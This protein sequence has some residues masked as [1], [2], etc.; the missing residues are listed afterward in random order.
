VEIRHLKL[1]RELAESGTL[2]AAG[3]RLF[4]TQPALSRQL[5][6]VENELGVAVFQ[7]AGRK[8]KLTQAGIRVH[9][10]ACRIVTELEQTMNDV[11]ALVTGGGILRF[12]T[13]CYT[14]YHW[15]PD[16]LTLYR[17]AYPAVEVSI[18][19][20]ATAD[21][22]Q[23]LRDGDLDVGLVNRVVPGA[24]LQY[25]RLFEDEDVVVVSREHRW[26]SRKFVRPAELADE[27]LIVFDSELRESNLFKNVLTPAGVTPKQVIK[28]P[29][30]EAIVD[31]IKAGLGISVMVRWAVSPYL[32]S[33]DLVPLRLTRGGARR[34]WYAVTLRENPRPP[35]I[36][37]FIA[38]LRENISLFQSGQD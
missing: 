14:C 12:V 25:H 22:I 9:R 18:N 30:T 20:A 36:K 23:S 4:L 26:A 11:N 10:G 7:R 37:E 32:R 21:P 24:D 8:M 5:R 33:S 1:I 28:L 35:Y 15:L 19:L 13:A 6:A 27:H 16:L 2:T 31:M 17:Q 34:T 38:L 3:K 29:M